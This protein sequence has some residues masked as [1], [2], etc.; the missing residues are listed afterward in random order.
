MRSHASAVGFPRAVSLSRL[1]C[2]RFRFGCCA[3]RR[4]L[5]RQVPRCP[6]RYAPAQSRGEILSDPP[7][8]TL[9]HFAPDLVCQRLGVRVP[10][11]MHLEMVAGRH[12]TKIHLV[13]FPGQPLGNNGPTVKTGVGAATRSIE[14]NDSV[15]RLRIFDRTHLAPDRPGPTLALPDFHAIALRRPP[16]LINLVQ[17]HAHVGIL[18]CARCA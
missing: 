1:L 3:P 11:G 9:L 4:E 8:G 10:P 16:L 6:P 15:A 13:L 17:P 18:P 2:A 12:G 5:W 7:E 14:E